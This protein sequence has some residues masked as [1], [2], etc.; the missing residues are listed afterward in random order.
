MRHQF[1][2]AYSTPVYAETLEFYADGLEFPVVESWDH[3]P[4]DRGTLFGAFSG[5]IEVL[6]LPEKPEE[7][8]SWDHRAPQGVSIVI[9]VE[10]V[11]DLHAKAIDHQLPV[12]ESI[13]NQ[14]WGHRS[15]LLLI[16]T[17]LRSI[18]IQ[19]ISR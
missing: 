9:E 16:Q 14:P 13:R 3:G 2:T 8:P 5:I 12:K 4:N 18:S 17:M 19:R 15:F 10:D 7:D 11:D 1:R 6:A